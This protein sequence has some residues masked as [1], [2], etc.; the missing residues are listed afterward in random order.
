[1]RH[2]VI[3][4]AGHVDHGK[5]S[6]VFAL[7]GVQ[8]DRLPEEQRRGITIE[9][10]FAPWRIR[11]DLLVS[12]IDAPGHRRLVHNMIAGA[13]GI[14]V[15][16]LVVAADEGVMPQ[17]R[18]HVAACKLLGVRRAVVAVT[19]IDRADPDLA[20]LAGEEARELLAAH[21]IESEVVRCS[22]KTGEGTDDVRRAVLAAV[23]HPA[24]KPHARRRARLGIDR[25][26]TVHG[27]GTVV[28]GTL[29]EGEI[30]VGSELRL[31]GSDR[32]LGATVRA[33]HVHG[34]ACERAQAPTRLAINLA[35]VKL[36]EVERGMMVT[37]DPKAQPT[38]LLDV[39]IDPIE[40]LRRGSDASIFIGT[41]R[42]IARVQP[43][44]GDDLVAPGMARLRLTAPLVALGGDRFVLRGANVDGPAGAVCGG[45]VVL[46]ARPPKTV[47]VHKRLELLQALQEGDSSRAMLALTRE[48]APESLPK[49]A[50]VSRFAI[51][52][53]NL[54]EAG[55]KLSQTELQIVGEGVWMVRSALESLQTHALEL[56]RAH[57]QAEPLQPGLEIQTL[58]ERL[59]AKSDEP[60][61]HAALQALTSG[62]KPKLVVNGPVVRLP[63]FGGA[64]SGTVAAQ[65]LERVAALV[66]AAKLDGVTENDLGGA[67]LDAKLARGA[68]AA[69][70]RSQ[71][72]IHAGAIWFHAPA[73]REL[74]ERI[75]AHFAASDVLTIADFKNLTGLSRK[76]AIPLLEHF[77]RTRLT[78]RAPSGDRIRGTS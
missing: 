33:L 9:L 12:I 35:G 36:D 28:T 16:L 62:N 32:E 7:T 72:V 75:R 6:L 29:V 30:A 59:V 71:S 42:S 49:T 73:V 66:A 53:I 41:A 58:R 44:E 27:S 25:V 48:C 56:V 78:R 14:D 63:S 22:A 24:S 64:G 45:G 69:L 68:L 51:D 20:E 60:A 10:G 21:G 43:A 34:Q 54:S 70:E 67:G 57:H 18:E 17:T 11:D 52:S 55:K 19:K 15:V 4:T 47:R 13:S 38:R 74:G 31:L 50:L 37:D 77:D 2:A 5:T 8:T 76:Q 61:T 26:F 39:W 1:V 3:G 23:D 65:T 40:P 46:D